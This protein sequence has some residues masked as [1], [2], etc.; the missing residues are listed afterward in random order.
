[1]HSS[2]FEGGI[3]AVFLALHAHYSERSLVN[4]T[5]D[6]PSLN[7]EK[8]DYILNSVRV[9]LKKSWTRPC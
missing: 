4:C 2:C 1:M 6:A 9:D 8:L 5:G 3:I 7:T